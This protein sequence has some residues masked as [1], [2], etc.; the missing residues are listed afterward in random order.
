M[1]HRVTGGTYAAGLLALGYAELAPIT[2]YRV[3]R[4]PNVAH[5]GLYY[6]GA[7]SMRFSPSGRISDSFPSSAV[8][9]QIV[10]D[11]ALAAAAG[12]TVELEG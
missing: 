9:K 8:K 7:Q 5:R 3:F 6:I 10:L 4:A 12:I 2:G 1:A 11:A